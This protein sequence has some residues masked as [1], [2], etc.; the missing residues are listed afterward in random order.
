MSNSNKLKVVRIDTH[1]SGAEIVTLE[2]EQGR[3]THK[4]KHTVEKELLLAYKGEI[5][6]SYKN[7]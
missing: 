6:N 4:M 7:K 3:L 1:Q 2:D 5:T